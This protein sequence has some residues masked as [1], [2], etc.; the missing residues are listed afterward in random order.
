[1]RY[2][3]DDW[4]P[5]PSIRE[6]DTLAALRFTLEDTSLI[7]EH[8]FYRGASA[9]ARLVFDDA[10]A[11]EVYLLERTRPGDSI[12][13]WRFDALCRDDNAVAHGKVPDADGQVPVRGAY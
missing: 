9:P 10:D 11:L 7:V 5:G 12:W 13:V 8:R 4:G 1:M 6:N 2:E 3:A